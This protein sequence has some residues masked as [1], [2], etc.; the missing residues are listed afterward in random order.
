MA[1]LVDLVKN[2]EVAE[3][4][5]SVDFLFEEKFEVFLLF[6]TLM[7]SGPFFEVCRV[8]PEHRTHVGLSTSGTWAQFPGS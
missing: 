7:N 4:S 6:K 8:D 5:N 1:G 3:E 2:S